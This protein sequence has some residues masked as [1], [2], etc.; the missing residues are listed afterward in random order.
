MAC[1]YSPESGWVAS[2]GL[3][4][5][6]SIYSLKPDASREGPIKV[7]REL[8]AHQGYLSCCKFLSESQILTGSGDWSCILWDIQ[9]NTKIQEFQDHTQD[10]ITLA[11]TGDKKNF[12]SAGIFR[13]SLSLFIPFLYLLPL[14]NLLPPFFFFAFFFC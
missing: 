8:M 7:S 10:V 1:D 2:G 6:C 11:V 13:F 4:N 14:A 5:I 3:D 12:V 9:G